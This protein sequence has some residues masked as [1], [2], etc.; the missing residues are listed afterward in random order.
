MKRLASLAVALGFAVALLVAG[1]AATC[2]AVA[3]ET[4]AKQALI[5]DFQTGTVMMEKN[6]DEPIHPAS[7][8]KL[9]TIYI[10]FDLLK[11]GRLKLD[12]AFPVSERAW[13]LREGSKMFVGIN[14]RIPLEELIRGIIVQSGNDAC[15][16]VAE[17]IAGSEEAFVELMNKKAKEIGLTHSHFA[18]SHGLEDP[19]H[20]MTARDLATL[21]KRVIVEFPDYY[22][23][24][25]EKEFVFNG[26]KQGNRNPLLYKDLGVDGL[27]TGHLG[28]S[29]FGL[30]VSAL[31]NGRRIIMVLHGMDGMQSRSDEAARLLEWAYRE[32]D[33]Y[34]VLKPGAAIVD[35]PVWYG[36]AATVPLVVKS[37]LLVTAPRNSIK[38]LKA[39]AVFE[40]PVRAPIAEGQ[41]IGKLVIT[42]PEI[43]PMEV[44]LYAGASVD[45]LGVFGRI[46]AG[47]RGIIVG[48]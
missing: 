40:G 13:A 36:E 25:S 7:M 48:G 31:R 34:Q 10:L 46:V 5:V 27:K 33:N 23:Y 43:S 16:V 9:M 21:A 37:D 14:S 15:V 42:A 8:S 6:A 35:A 32:F 28:V 4:A 29:G 24:F 18:N 30:A 47:I 3:I 26:I 19:D 45:R 1:S 44:P 20:K 22:H 17:G 12:D 38:D 39:K 41:E 2:P 11:Q